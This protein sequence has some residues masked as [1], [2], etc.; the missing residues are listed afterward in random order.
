[1]FVFYFLNI[2]NSSLL[3][4]ISKLSILNVLNLV[5]VYIKSSNYLELKI[6]TPYFLARRYF[7]ES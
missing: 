6:V 4:K 7:E 2:H 3:L 5:Y 1:M